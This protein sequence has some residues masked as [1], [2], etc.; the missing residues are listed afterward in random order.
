M[1]PA[2]EGDKSLGCALWSPFPSSDTNEIDRSRS[3][4]RRKSYDSIREVQNSIPQSFSDSN[5]GVERLDTDGSTARRLSDTYL[6][7][8]LSNHDRFAARR[9]R[10]SETNLRHSLESFSNDT[11]KIVT[12][13]VQRRSTSLDSMPFEV[14]ELILSYLLCQPR[15]HDWTPRNADVIACLRTSKAMYAATLSSLYRN[16]TIPHSITFSKVLRQVSSDPEL[17][18]LVRRLDFS[19][20]TSVGFGRTRQAALAL[21]NVTPRT[22]RQCLGLM[23]GLTEFLVHEHIDDELDEEVLQKLLFESK[24]RALDFCGCSSRTF[25]QAFSGVLDSQTASFPFL[26]RLS[27]HECSTLQAPF[28]EALL[29]RLPHL[30]HLDLAHTVITDE[31]LISI[32]P[33]ARLT[34][35]NLGRCTQL[36]GARVVDFLK[37]HDAVKELVVLNLM[38]DVSRYTLLYEEDLEELIPAL[39]TTLRSLNLGGAKI[40]S[41]TIPLLLPLTKVLEELG[42]AYADI[43]V[44]DVNSFF[45]PTLTISNY[46]SEEEEMDWQPWEPCSLRY[47][48]LT[49]VA[50]ISQTSITDPSC[51]LVSQQ[52]YPLEVVEL[53]GDVIKKLQD[54]SKSNKGLGWVV[55]ELGRRGWFV[56]QAAGSIVDDG[57]RPWKMGARWWG[58]RKLPVAVQEVGGMYGHYMFK[59]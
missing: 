34:H 3:R 41:S 18:A 11:A 5:R 12:P 57:S 2:C 40:K 38:A 39:P 15:P 27:L 46:I 33:S 44:S 20:Y 21:Q 37:T 9:H 56:K 58:M 42:L 24:L 8:S 4:P 17:G 14:I 25:T 55:K 52:S 26:R 29:P 16:I 45:R 49:G 54:R 53:G 7:V 43:S 51:V 59:C 31:V 6:A 36:T 47:L 32:P 1:P 28:F 19:R 30:T 23:P 48:D 50:S 10:K 22:L 35:L 13:E